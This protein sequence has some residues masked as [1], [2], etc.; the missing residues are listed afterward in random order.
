MK[1]FIPFLLV[2][3]LKTGHVNAQKKERLSGNCNDSL[4]VSDAIT[5]I[6]KDRFHESFNNHKF[7]FELATIDTNVFFGA[8]T[9][10]RLN[11]TIGVSYP[12]APNVILMISKNTCEYSLFSECWTGHSSGKETFYEEKKKK[13]EMKKE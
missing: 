5:K 8:F 1:I 3:C 9:F 12:S 13:R 2:L 11:D 10:Y 7:K 6:A 4:Y